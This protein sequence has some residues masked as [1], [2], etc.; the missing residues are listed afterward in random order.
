MQVQSYLNFDGRC[1]EALEYYKRALGA[2]VDALMRYGDNPEACAMMPPGS[3]GKVL[4]SSFTI[5]E[6]RVMASDCECRG[7]PTF[8]G[9]SLS[10]NPKTEPEAHKLFNALAD[11]GKAQMP[12]TK[13]FF[14]PCFG[15]VADKFGLNWMIVVLP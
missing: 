1:E 2:K 9:F 11:G 4:H 3:Q 10:L 5:G 14:S 15:T 12:L 6:T 7:Q 13:T 8:Q